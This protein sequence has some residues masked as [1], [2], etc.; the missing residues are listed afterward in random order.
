ALPVF[1]AARTNKLVW[2]VSAD[3]LD[4]RYPELQALRAAEN[5]QSWGAVPIVFEDRTLGA[6]GFRCHYE[7]PLLP[8]EESMLIAVG[9]QCGL[10]VERARLHDAAELARA[11][12]E[13]ASRAKDEFLAMLGHE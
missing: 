13:R 10:A 5:I 1:D 3:A 7:R 6:I 9:R 8:E 11:Q 12:A 2:V 4:E